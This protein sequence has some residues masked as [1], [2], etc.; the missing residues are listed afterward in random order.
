TGIEIAENFQMPPALDKAWHTHGYYGSVSHNVKAVYQRYMGWFDGNPGR[1]WAHPPEA[2]GPRYVEAMG[3]IERVVEIAQKAFDDGDFRWA[4]TLLDHAIF[5]DTDHA[6]ARGLY[7]D[8]LEQLAY[9]SE[10][11]VWRNFF[12]SGMTE[13]REGNFG[14]PTQTASPS[15]MAQLTPEQMF[16]TFAININGPRA[17]KLD[18]AIDIT[19][20]DVSTNYRLTLRNGV[21]VYRKMPPDESTAQATIKLSNKMRLLMFA[22]GD[23]DS[24][25]LDMTGD[26]NA[27]PSI[28]AVV[29]RPDPGFNI[30]EP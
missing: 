18:V 5:A 30:I 8:T 3:G 9:G 28:M 7:A 22:A 24:P 20:A 10:N 15:M 26:P 17:W 12:L 2:I 27:L 21:L 11:A 16:D 19:F 29:D 4:A 14:T 23:A 25:G 1:L 13:L 6:G